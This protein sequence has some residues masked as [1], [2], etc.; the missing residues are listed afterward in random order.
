M[1]AAR[2]IPES[3]R[4]AVHRILHTAAVRVLRREIGSGLAVLADALRDAMAQGG[5]L[6]LTKRERYVLGVLLGVRPFTFG[7]S[8]FVLQ[9]VEVRNG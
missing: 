6:P 9:G 2:E 3:D 1:S 7:G 5:G 4:M 8:V